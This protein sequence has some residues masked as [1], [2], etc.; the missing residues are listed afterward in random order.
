L[1][2][3]KIELSIDV[4]FVFLGLGFKTYYFHFC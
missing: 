1:D 3:G 4:K 2:R